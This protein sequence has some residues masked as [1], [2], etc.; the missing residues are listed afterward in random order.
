MESIKKIISCNINY[1]MSWN[2]AIF[3]LLIL[4]LLKYD[5]NSSEYNIVE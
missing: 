4:G 5:L 1:E 3:I 2:E